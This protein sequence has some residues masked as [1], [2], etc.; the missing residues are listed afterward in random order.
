MTILDNPWLFFVLLLA[1]FLL[2]EEIGYR[3]ARRRL[4]VQSETKH[5][6]IEE[7]RNQI[8]VLLSLLLGFT[9]SMAL[10]R[11]EIR[12]ELV[13]N[14][15]NAIGTTYLR[16]QMLPEP[17]RTKSMSLLREYVDTRVRWI[18]APNPD[19]A[20]LQGIADAKRIQ[21]D[22][23]QIAVPLAQATPNPIISIYAQTLN[24][25]IDLDEK[26]IAARLNRIPTEIWLM[27]VVLGGITCFTIGL[28][29]ESRLAVAVIVPAL[30]L[31]I[32]MG[33]VADIES[34]RSGFIMV[35]QDS[36][37]RVYSDIHAALPTTATP[38]PSADTR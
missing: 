17:A 37:L 29:Q 35:S 4:G 18:K 22:L 8:A 6:Q 1:G 10:S 38:S 21:D 30:M 23:W 3:V 32:V 25:M 16:A 33:L 12:K 34:S 11:F 5:K 20:R 27:L 31:S 19:Q 2:V 15:A 26:R 14:E 36:L 24:D 28:G 7:T 9:L 13:V